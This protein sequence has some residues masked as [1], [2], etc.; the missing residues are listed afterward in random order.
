MLSLAAAS[1]ALSAPTPPILPLRVVAFPGASPLLVSTS[2]TASRVVLVHRSAQGDLASVGAEASAEQAAPGVLRCTPLARCRIGDGL[3][4]VVDATDADAEFDDT[5]E[6]A[7]RV[8]RLLQ[9]VAELS[10]QSVTLPTHVRA[11]APT[12]T[13]STH[14]EF[15]LAVCSLLELA[16]SQQQ[17]LLE[18]TCTGERLA[19][20]YKGGQPG[21]ATFAVGADGV[22]SRS[23]DGDAPLQ[24][25]PPPPPQLQP[26]QQPPGAALASAGM[27]N[28]AVLPEP[29]G[30]QTTVSR[31]SSSVGIACICTGDGSVHC[32]ASMFR[33]SVARSLSSRGRKLSSP[34][35]AIGSGTR[36]PLAW[37]SIRRRKAAISSVC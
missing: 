8:W 9:E 37:M 14:A 10:E 7:A 4:P 27:T 25:A 2:V 26:P 24:L 23:D 16:P 17:Q 34:K 22:R 12:A 11:L 1:C 13:A 32:D 20:L 35:V 31:P 30:A 18:C 21:E 19:S 15:S 33:R 36:S 29:V 6:E 3:T 28:A 5:A